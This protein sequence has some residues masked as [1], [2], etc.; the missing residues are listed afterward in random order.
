MEH[1]VS[2]VGGAGPGGGGAAWVSEGPASPVAAPRAPGSGSEEAEAGQPHA[3]VALDNKHNLAQR[4]Q[5][6]A[7]VQKG[8]VAHSVERIPEFAEDISPYATFHVQSQPAAS[9]PAHIQAFVYHD[10]R[11][12]A[13]ETMKLKSE[14][15]EP[16]G[17]LAACPG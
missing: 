7:A 17:L 11:L 9:S 10:H 1:R 5:Y 16:P 8:M 15:P 2:E 4:E 6:Y 14:P 13:M 12:A 3:L